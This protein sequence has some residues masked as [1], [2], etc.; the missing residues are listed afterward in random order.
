[1]D[2][3]KILGVDKDATDEEIKKAYR[4]LAMKYHPD[5]NSGNKNAEEKFKQINEAY[6]V[7]SDPS[8]KQEYEFSGG[9]GNFNFEHNDVDLNDIINAFRN[10]HSHYS[11]FDDL[12]GNRKRQALY[13]I[14]LNFW[15]AVFGTKKLIKT[16]HQEQH[17]TI[18]QEVQI[19]IPSGVENG[20]N[21][22]IKA[23]NVEFLIQVVVKGDNLFERNGLDLSV[24]IVIPYSTACLGGTVTFPHWEGDIMV[25]IPSGMQNDK[26]LRLTGKGIKKGNE[27][28][29]LYL[30]VKIHVPTELTKKQK[31][32]LQELDKTFEQKKS[33]SFIGK[34]AEFWDNLKQK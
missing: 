19:N 7:L 9:S 24:P 4:K 6:S 33:D 18:T 32:L 17:K 21:L 23:D 2:Y 15:E 34:A 1:M 3:Y 26:K 25:S 20:D 10:S 28:G 16:Q 8:K 22:K 13:R 12:F 11:H 14:E 31:E 29:N 30:V 5:R 27:K